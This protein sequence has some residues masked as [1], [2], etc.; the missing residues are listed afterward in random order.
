MNE[1]VRH[2]S[3]FVQIID[4]L[5][6]AL[7]TQG[8]KTGFFQMVL[9]I[10]QTCEEEAIPFSFYC[11]VKIITKKQE[12]HFN[13]CFFFHTNPK[14]TDDKST[15]TDM[16]LHLTKKLLHSKENKQQSEKKTYRT[17]ENSGTLFI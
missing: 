1:K 11:Q 9:A 4:F 14:D 13:T 10:G 8:E 17:G 2:Q 3:I 12:K 16:W 15:N 5:K 6:M 7:R